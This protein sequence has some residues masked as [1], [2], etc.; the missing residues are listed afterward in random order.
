MFHETHRLLIHPIQIEEF[1][2]ILKRNLQPHYEVISKLLA[3]SGT[4]DNKGLLLE[5]RTDRQIFYIFCALMRI[6][7]KH[8]FS[9][10]TAMNT[11]AYHGKSHSNI[12]SFFGITMLPYSLNRKL[13][14]LITS[15][16][17]ME[18]GWETL[19]ASGTFG[20]FAMDNSQF[21][22]PMKYQRQGMSSFLA[23]FTTR[24]AF[25]CKC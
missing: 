21:K 7:N 2:L 18:I 14:T 9:W 8:Y 11:A 10:W 22:V 24:C 6:R 16:K 13:K 1:A 5:P 20:G 25:K 17:V 19:I 23:M 3:K 15:A 12:T 4:I